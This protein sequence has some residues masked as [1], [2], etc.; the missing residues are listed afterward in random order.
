MNAKGEARPL[1]GVMKSN[2][3]IFVLLSAAA[4]ASL[5]TAGCGK[6]WTYAVKC[7]GDERN[8]VSTL[9]FPKEFCACGT[10]LSYEETRDDT[11]RLVESHYVMRRGYL[12][13]ASPEVR[14][15]SENGYELSQLYIENEEGEMR[16]VTRESDPAEWERNQDLL[17]LLVE[18][19]LSDMVVA[20]TRCEAE[21]GPTARRDAMR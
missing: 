5:L 8:T 6:E 14:M 19:Y 16:E 21:K 13:E 2:R 18:E 17:E 11:G 3:F 12:A 1:T 10:S 7:A 20:G 9:V 4:A 15:V